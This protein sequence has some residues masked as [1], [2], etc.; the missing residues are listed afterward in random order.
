MDPQKGEF[1]NIGKSLRNTGRSSLEGSAGG[2]F[3]VHC[4][5]GGTRSMGGRHTEV[6][7]REIFCSPLECLSSL[8]THMVPS[9]LR[10]VS[11]LAEETELEVLLNGCGYS[12]SFLAEELVGMID[13]CL[14]SGRC[15]PDDLWRIREVYNSISA[16]HEGRSRRIAAWG[17]NRPGRADTAMNSRVLSLS[18]T[19][20]AYSGHA[21]VSDAR[22]V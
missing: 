8:R 15:T 18:T 14:G 20:R 21:G 4:E 9:I 5:N 3:I 11:G 1:M 19:R 13:D 6:R 2:F 12:V 10:E 22:A 7:N 17:H 16:F